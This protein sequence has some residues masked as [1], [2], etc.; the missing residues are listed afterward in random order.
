MSSSHDKPIGSLDTKYVNRHASVDLAF[1]TDA[2][3]KMLKN[4]I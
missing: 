3:A 4:A 1:V 2:A